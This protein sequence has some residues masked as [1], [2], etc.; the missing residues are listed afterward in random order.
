MLRPEHSPARLQALGLERLQ[1]VD[2]RRF[3]RLSPDEA[4][5][6]EAQLDEDAQSL[7]TLAALLAQRRNFICSPLLQLPV[8]L[9]QH[10][11]RFVAEDLPLLGEESS[12]SDD[13]DDSDSDSDDSSE[14]SSSSDAR[15]GW[16]SLGHVSSHIRALLLAMRE[17]WAGSICEAPSREVLEEVALRACNVPLTLHLNGSSPLAAWPFALQNLHKAR[18]ID[19]KFFDD[20]DQALYDKLCW[21]ELP[22][23][24]SMRLS[25]ATSS[26]FFLSPERSW[27]R[28]F[29]DKSEAMPYMKA[30]NLRNLQLDNV[31]LP[32]D[33]S[34]LKTLTLVGK[35]SYWRDVEHTP[36]S[37]LFLDMLRSCSQLHTLRI[38]GW[39]PDFQVGEQ[40]SPAALPS[41]RTLTMDL[42]GKQLARLWAH[43]TIPHT[44]SVIVDIRRAGKRARLASRLKRVLSFFSHV[45]SEAVSGMFIGHELVERV[46]NRDRLRVVLFTRESKAAETMPIDLPQPNPFED[47]HRLL[48][49]I[50]L[51][52]CTAYKSVDDL[53]LAMQHLS[54]TFNLS[55]LDTLGIDL[56]GTSIEHHPQVSISR[57]FSNV[58]TLCV[59]D[60]T[61][62]ELDLIRP[63]Y[64]DGEDLV[65]FNIPLLR[66]LYLPYTQA[67]SFRIDRLRSFVGALTARVE[68]GGSSIS[69]VYTSFASSCEASSESEFVS[70]LRGAVA[71]VQSVTFE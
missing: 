38:V 1:E 23:L 17:L 68:A 57:C 24:Q 22:L 69:T 41:L 49:S 35:R 9:L 42:Y 60:A 5:A 4:T 15:Y 64:N 14:D 12:D 7:R 45:N 67:D 52:R 66:T 53:E 71:S 48:L 29:D 56:Q 31:F 11:I 13:S 65:R 70:S 20:D 10:I 33:P 36:S 27:I 62:A 30:P 40:E 39:V 28:G 46:T 54:S 21:V 26:D 2:A 50:N 47:D 3:S 8:E 44:A 59:L 63:I 37:S 25:I 34:T 61:S 18:H 51:H 16:S 6:L 58:H 19:V 32:F 55:Q 43:I